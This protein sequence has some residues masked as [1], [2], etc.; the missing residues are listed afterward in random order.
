MKSR[1]HMPEITPEVIFKKKKWRN[2]FSTGKIRKITIKS[3][4][5]INC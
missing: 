1:D 2:G 4:W 3:R 5:I